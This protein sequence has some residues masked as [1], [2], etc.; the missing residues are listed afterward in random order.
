MSVAFVPYTDEE[1]HDLLTDSGLVLTLRESRLLATLD[2][3]YKRRCSNCRHYSDTWGSCE[4][5][6]PEFDSPRT[7]QSDFGC[8]FWEDK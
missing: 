2:A 6:S 7:R 1:L 8:Q 4:N 3:I 5:P